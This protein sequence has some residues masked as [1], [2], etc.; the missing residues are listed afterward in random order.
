MTRL[1]ARLDVV[2]S[3]A[4]LMAAMLLVMWAEHPTV[5][6]TMPREAVRRLILTRDVDREHLLSDRLEAARIERRYTASQAGS[7]PHDDGLDTCE[8]TLAREIVATHGVTADQAR[9]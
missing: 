9:R 8:A 5:T 4:I 7:S 6:C 1:A 3:V 2:A